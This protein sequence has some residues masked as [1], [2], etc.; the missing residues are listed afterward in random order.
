MT[1]TPTN[2]T[3]GGRPPLFGRAMTAKGRKKRSLAARSARLRD[4][5]A[6]DY[7]PNVLTGEQMFAALGMV[8]PTISDAELARLRAMPGGSDPD[9]FDP[10][11]EPEED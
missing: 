5:A 9:D 10:W 7:F 11:A 3:K 2:V 4:A 6:P 8:P 1:D